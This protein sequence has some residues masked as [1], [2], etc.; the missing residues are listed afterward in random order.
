MLDVGVFTLTRSMCSAHYSIVF[1]F[2]HCPVT[3]TGH[4]VFLIFHFC[5]AWFRGQGTLF[6][7]FFIF[8]L[9]A[10]GDRAHCFLIFYFVH[11]PVSRAGHTVFLI[12]YFCTAQFLGLGTPFSCFFFFALP[13]LLFRA[14]YFLV[15]HFSDC[16]INC[17]RHT[18]SLF[19]CFH[20]DS[21]R[22]NTL[23]QTTLHISNMLY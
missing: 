14:H 2:S 11:C 1:S 9:P 8:T 13:Q 10:F 20:T 21:T 18:F 23:I 16:S 19:W 7:R 3:E 22:Y 4:T 12:F 17:P 15:F 6:S 5:T